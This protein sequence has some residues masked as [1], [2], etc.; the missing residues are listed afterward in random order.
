MMNAHVVT[1]RNREQARPAGAL[2]MVRVTV[3]ALG[4]VPVVTRRKAISDVHAK[5]DVAIA[6]H[7]A[8]GLQEAALLTLA[9]TAKFPNGQTRVANH[10]RTVACRRLSLMRLPIRTL[11]SVFERNLRP[12]RLKMLR[13]WPGILQW[14]V[15]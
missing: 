8:R 12:S 5:P 7:V 3:V 15:C 2:A 9:N 6:I 14:S 1:L 4:D 10:L 11:K 13:K